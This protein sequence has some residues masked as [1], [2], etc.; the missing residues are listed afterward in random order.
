MNHPAYP[1]AAQRGHVTG[2]V[3]LSDRQD[4]SATISGAWVGL[5]APSPDWQQQSLG[6]QFWVHAD[7][8]GKF[9]IPNVRAGSYTLYAFVNGVMDEFR[10]DDINV[11]PGSKIDLGELKWT[12]KRFGQQLWQ[13]GTPDRT[14]KEFRHGD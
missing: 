2:R 8:D 3:A 13:I 1:L 10:V 9:D 4:A 11:K 12:P 6:Y 7:K 5:A 14:A